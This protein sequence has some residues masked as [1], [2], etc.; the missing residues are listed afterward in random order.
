M[1]MQVICSNVH[2]FYYDTDY[3]FQKI[4]EAGYKKVELYLGTPHIFIDGNVIDD[5]NHAADCAA[6]YGCRIVSVHPETL[7]FRYGLCCE[8]EEWNKKSVAV[9]K[10][11]IDYANQIG[12]RRLNTNITG[13]FRDKD[14]KR[15]MS[16]V[17]HNLREINRYG[18][19]QGVSVALEAEAD[20]YEGFLSN[21]KDI[22]IV[23]DA[24]NDENLKVNI[25]YD[26]L[27]HANETVSEWLEVYRDRCDFIRFSSLEDFQRAQAEIE[28]K[29]FEGNVG[30]FLTDDKYLDEPY[31]EDTR[32][33]EAVS[34]KRGISPWD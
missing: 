24:V 3:F 30:F 34:G 2:Y 10:R 22:Q 23:A 6:R 13:A 9:Y 28:E 33:I 12:V 15:T 27:K 8:D 31:K 7:S 32:I 1:G 26:A 14:A 19:E 21:L 5:F 17:I 18:K 4:S 16:R 20:Y 25:N 11:C 29:Q